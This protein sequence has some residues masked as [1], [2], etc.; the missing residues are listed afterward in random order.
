MGQRFNISSLDMLRQTKQLYKSEGELPSITTVYFHET[1]AR[2]QRDVI[3]RKGRR[4]MHVGRSHTLTLCTGELKLLYSF[5][6]PYVQ[7]KITGRQTKNTAPAGAGYNTTDRRLGRNEP[8]DKS[9]LL[10]MH[11]SPKQHSAQHWPEWAA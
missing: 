4:R 6:L 8:H 10:W 9:N 2:P 7:K 3:K 1:S 11:R 5:T